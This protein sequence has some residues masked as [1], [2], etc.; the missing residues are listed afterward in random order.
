MAE[1]EDRGPRSEAEED[2]GFD[3]SDPIEI[4]EELEEDRPTSEQAP[5]EPGPASDN[6]QLDNLLDEFV[7]VVNARDLDDL[8]DLLRAETEAEFLGEVTGAGVVEGLNDLFLRY[9]TL[10]ATRGDIGA[11]PVVAMWIFDQDA[12]R[13]DPFGYFTFEIGESEEPLIQ[14]LVYNEELP[15]TEDVV[16]EI[17]DRSD[18]AEWEDWSELD[19][20]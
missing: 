19:E 18:L 11:E 3:V 6:T 5:D 2:L 8:G 15:D 10:L 14:R 17:P 4:G 12:D 9:P 20:D 16:V 1:T 7:E 13:F